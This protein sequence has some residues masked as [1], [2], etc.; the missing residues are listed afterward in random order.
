MDPFRFKADLVV[1]QRHVN[2]RKHVSY[3]KYFVL[4]QE[5]RI[6]YLALF[7]YRSNDSDGFGLIAAEARCTYK[8]ELR[9]GDRIAIGCR[10]KALKPNAFVMEFQITRDGQVCA[11]GD[12][13]YLCF[14]YAANRVASFPERLIRC[15]RDH[16]G[17]E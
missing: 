4:F 1:L 11:T 7:G 15:I 5:A 8:K 12:T 9:Q 10:V 13:T 6:G 2:D 3:D 17:M 16:E 14:D